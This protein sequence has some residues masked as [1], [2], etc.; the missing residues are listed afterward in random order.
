MD[1]KRITSRIDIPP[2]EESTEVGR[3]PA[4]GRSAG[5]GIAAARDGFETAQK[6]SEFEKALRVGFNPQPDPPIDFSAITSS[7]PFI[8]PGTEKMDPAEELFLMPQSDGQEISRLTR[9]PEDPMP[10]ATRLTRPPEDP[11]PAATK[12]GALSDDTSEG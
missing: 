5:K 9:P 3:A 10:A 12:L 7:N 1:I 4:S 8:S 6:P 11:M 2:S